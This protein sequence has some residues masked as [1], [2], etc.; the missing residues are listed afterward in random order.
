[1]VATYTLRLLHEGYL[2]TNTQTYEEYAEHNYGKKASVAVSVCVIMINLG[3]MIAYQIIIMDLVLP[4]VR[5]AGV[6]E[7]QV[8]DEWLRRFISVASAAV[9]FAISLPK[10]ITTFKWTS[11]VSLLFVVAFSGI[12]VVFFAQAASSGVALESPLLFNFSHRIFLVLGI[13][14]FAYSCHS[15]M[16][17][18][19]AEVP[20]YA[21]GRIWGSVLL[22]TGFCTVVY[23]LVGIFGYL[24]FG[25]A[26]PAQQIAPHHV[27]VVLGDLLVAFNFEIRSPG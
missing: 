26:A 17:P 2:L 27:G 10:Q 18:I 24:T 4:I 23:V 11:L 7:A 19:V 13:V 21:Q 14:V 9:L 3:S 20:G 6:L 25:S 22:S 8:G 5:R 12:V 1:M 16:F 15:N